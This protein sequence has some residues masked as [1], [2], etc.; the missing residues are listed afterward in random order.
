MRGRIEAQVQE[1]GL[2]DQVQF[3]G[4]QPMSVVREWLAW[5]DIG[6]LACCIGPFGQ[7]DGIPNFLT[8]CLC[9]GRPVVSTQM[10]GVKELVT[11][12]EQGLLVRTRDA[13]ALADAIERLRNDPELRRRMSDAAR[14]LVEAEH[15]VIVNTQE[16][17]DVYVEQSGRPV[18]R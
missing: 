9:T 4:K 2:T 10:D 6:V 7:S 16:L 15:D 8:E 17:F 11:D 13:A 14:A 12:G 3:L 5:S 1:L 18:G